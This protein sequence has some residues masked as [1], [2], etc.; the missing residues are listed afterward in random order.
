V[1]RWAEYEGLDQRTLQWLVDEGLLRGPPGW[2]IYSVSSMDA[3][4]VLRSIAD[5][6]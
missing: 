3:A 4:V 1:F 2:D 6:D 5:D